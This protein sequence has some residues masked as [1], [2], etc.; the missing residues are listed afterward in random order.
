MGLFKSEEERAAER[1]ERERVQAAQQ[2]ARAAQ[3]A[4]AAQE[5]A[6]REHAASPLGRAEAAHAAGHGFFEIQLDV[7]QTQGVATFG[8]ARA[9]ERRTDAHLGVLGAIEQVGWRLEHVGYVFVQTGQESTDKF[10]TTGQRIAVTGKTV[11][12]YLFR[13]A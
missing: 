1:A 3:Q 5:Q 8:E 2:Q 11:G 4:Q 12:I 6:A 10:V 7:G 9:D 13:R